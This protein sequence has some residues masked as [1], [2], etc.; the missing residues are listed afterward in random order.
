MKDKTSNSISV[1]VVCNKTGLHNLK[2]DIVLVSNQREAAFVL[3]GLLSLY[4][5]RTRFASIFR[6]NTQNCNG[7]H[8]CVS[9]RVR[10]SSPVSVVCVL[11]QDYFIPHAL[12]HTGGCHYSF[13]YYSWRWTRTASETCRVIINQVKQKLHLVGYLLIQYYRDKHT[14]TLNTVSLLFVTK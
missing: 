13:V 2:S 3:L 6:S 12:T 4:M 11:R 14:V 1:A 7:S 10:W 8:Q 9:M 5:F